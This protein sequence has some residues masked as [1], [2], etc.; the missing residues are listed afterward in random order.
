[1]LHAFPSLACL[2]LYATLACV[3][4]PK[5]APP[6]ART[7]APP[8]ANLGRY[9]RPVTTT[10]PDAQRRFDEGLAYMFAFNHDEAMRS[11]EAAERLDPTCAMCAWGVALACGPHINQPRV[12]AERARRAQEALGR[13]EKGQATALERGLMAAQA[14]RYGTSPDADR[15]PLDRAYADAM[16]TLWQAHPTDPD[17]GALFAEAAMDLRPWDL[18]RPDGEPQPGTEEIVTTLAAV[19][20]LAP[21]HPL[22]NHLTI[23]ALETSRH[24]ERAAEAADRL[25]GLT[26]D[27]GHL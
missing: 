16:R 8:V 13:A 27:L 25:R 15:G 11:F 18:W 7:G 26:P 17:V 21:L 4:R 20:A 10:S 5:V 12:P 19:V 3:P 23:H 14:R 2:L 22:A 24:P 6:A 9:T 1:M